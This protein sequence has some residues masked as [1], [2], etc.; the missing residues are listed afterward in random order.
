MPRLLYILRGRVPPGPDPERD[1]FTYLSEIAEGEVLLPVWWRSPEEA[2]SHLRGPFPRY[3]VGKFCY[4]QFLDR[5]HR[6]F[7]RLA[8]FSFYVRRGF[9]LHRQKQFDAI[10]SYG[11]NLTGIAGVVLKW[12]T[13]AKLIA[14]LPNVPTNA[15]RYQDSDEGTIA[16]IKRFVA[17]LG[18]YFVC[19]NSDCINILYPWQLREYPRLQRRRIAVFPSFVPLHTIR[20]VPTNEKFIL[21]VG[22]PW[23]TKGADLL[24]RAFKS[25]AAQFP[26]WKLKLLGH[27]PDRAHL[28]KLAEG[29]TQIEILKARPNSE[30]IKIIGSCSLFVLP[31]RT[32]AAP[33]V[34]REAMAA[35]KPILASDVGGVAY[36]V[37]DSETGLLFQAGNVDDLAD[38]LNTLLRD[39]EL[40]S[41]LAVGGHKMIMSEFDERAFLRFTDGMLKS[42]LP[43]PQENSRAVLSET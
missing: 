20:E 16:A 21:L 36:F 41:R 26:D 18:L 4:H 14:V 1:S 31:S 9:Q 28:D 27:Y 10:L 24:I 39:P 37:R 43:L 12:V 35:Q 22:F 42:I 5:R 17:N 13:G 8:R 3:R 34:V 15:Y 23:Y 7:G 25:I 40:R 33:R 29:C 6:A 32:D 38:K 30:A 19:L 11:T 2:D